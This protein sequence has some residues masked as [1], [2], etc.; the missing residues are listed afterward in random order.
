MSLTCTFEYS[1][2]VVQVLK[3]LNDFNPFQANVPLLHPLKMSVNQMFSVVFGVIEL[4]L[5]HRTQVKTI[6]QKILSILNDIKNV[7]G[8]FSCIDLL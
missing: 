6:G 1:S 8:F 5:Y 3:V 2:L 7:A 4:E